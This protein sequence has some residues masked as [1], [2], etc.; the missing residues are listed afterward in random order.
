LYRILVIYLLDFYSEYTRVPL[1]QFY[2][3]PRFP[4]DP[5]F[6]CRPG[7]VNLASH[8]FSQESFPRSLIE[9]FV[10]DLW[11]KLLEHWASTRNG[12]EQTGGIC[13]DGF[14]R[15]PN[16]RFARQSYRIFLYWILSQI[17]L[18]QLVV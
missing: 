5:S 4:Y 15:T 7:C 3:E 18:E 13:K 14:P 1:F 8:L 6:I 16:A 12:S 11:N 17:F 9:Y 10:L 2:R